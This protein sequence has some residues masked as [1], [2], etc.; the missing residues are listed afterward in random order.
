MCLIY[1]C[2]LTNSSNCSIIFSCEYIDA[3]FLNLHCH[4]CK[5]VTASLCSISD[6]VSVNKNYNLIVRCAVCNFEILLYKNWLTPITYAVTIGDDRLRFYPYSKKFQYIEP[7]DEFLIFN[8][9]GLE[10]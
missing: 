8:T 10:N 5:L 1:G 9:N 7:K 6:M 3:V 2:S 4:Q